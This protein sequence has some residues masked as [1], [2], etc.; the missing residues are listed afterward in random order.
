M[1]DVITYKIIA[2]HFISTATVKHYYVV[3]RTYRDY[4]QFDSQVF[5]EHLCGMPRRSIFLLSVV[6]SKLTLL[7]LFLLILFYIHS[8]VN[9]K[10]F[11]K[12]K[13]PLITNNDSNP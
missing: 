13:P 3:Y 9:T 12:R 5:K 8:F 7:D 2:Y 11:F 1:D 10:T 4:L 6:D